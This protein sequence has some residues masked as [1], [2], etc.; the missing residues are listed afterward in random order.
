MKKNAILLASLLLAARCGS[1]SSPP[2]PDGAPP[3]VANPA[4]GGPDAA[5]AQDASRVDGRDGAA[6]T[7]TGATLD[8]PPGPDA[9]DALTS[10]PD[11]PVA[12]VSCSPGDA[13]P[14]VDPAVAT[15]VQMTNDRILTVGSR[16]TLRD[17]ASGAVIAGGAIDPRTIAV[18]PLTGTV[19]GDA[20]LGGGLIAVR[21]GSA[22]D[23]RSASDGALIRSLGFTPPTQ[24]VAFGVAIDGSY[25]W[26]TTATGLTVWSAVGAH[27][28][29]VTGD[30]SAA[31]PFGAVG[32]VRVG[33]GPEGA[34]VIESISVPL[35]VAT[36]SAAFV[37]VFE[38]WF[39][40][41]DRFFAATGTTARIYS[42]AAQVQ[43]T[44]SLPTLNGLVGSA[45]FFMIG[46]N[47]DLNVY[48]VGTAAPIEHRLI[49]DISPFLS[50]RTLGLFGL[51]GEI[52]ILTLGAGVPVESKTSTA[53]S[54]FRSFAA[55]STGGWAAVDQNG[56]LFRQP[57]GGAVTIANCP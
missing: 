39:L 55:A 42:A 5:V 38:S 8:T 35:G 7:D 51:T 17:A 23:F 6:V 40:D 25:V 31:K 10:P 12:R 46:L 9:A 1:D 32:A 21:T 34:D 13:G 41:G 19:S 53:G 47:N 4:D 3:D 11:A 57:P 16:W 49:P 26:A 52:S 18:P 45:D 30:F 24:T 28:F 37:G 2:P 44:M 20:S 27:L 50:A 29:D 14:P 48:R 54:R 15:S 43:Q 22:L 56:L 36:K 33:N